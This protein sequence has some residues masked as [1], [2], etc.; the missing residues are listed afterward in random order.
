MKKLALLVGAIVLTSS[1]IAQRPTDSNP[2]SLEGGLSINSL[3]NTFSA[4]AL[5][6][7]YFAAENIAVRL[8]IQYNSAK[9]TNLYYGSTALG[10]PTADSTGTYVNRKAMTWISIGG[11]YHFSQLEK[12]S[13]YVSLDLMIGT[14]TG[15]AGNDT[16]TDCVGTSYSDGVSSEST[17]KSSGLGIGI[18]AGFDYY[19]AENVFIGA[20]LGMTYMS[21]NDKGGTY[22]TTSGGITTSGD[23]LTV[24]KSS[25]FGNSANAAIRLG[26]RF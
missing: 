23:V 11:S 1:A 5:R 3:T 8:G 13:P 7:R 15:I 17:T 9:T 16:R 6:L 12:L 14:G 22:S 2:F 24:G 21:T 10:V 19:F 20:E 26:W 25:S 18:G 4:P